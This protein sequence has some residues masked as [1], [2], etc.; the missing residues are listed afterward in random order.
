HGVTGSGKTEVYFEL[1]Q[2]TIERGKRGLFLVP[3]ISLTPQLIERFSRRF[4][5]EFAVIHSG[6]TDR[7]RT[8]FWWD[9]VEKRKKILIGVRSAL[10]CPIDDL[11][12]VIVDEEHEP[13]YKQD[14][15]FRYHARDAAVMLGKFFDCPVILGSATPSMESW[16]NIQQGKFHYHSIP[17]RV[18]IAKLPEVTMVDLREEKNKCEEGDP[19]WLSPTLKYK[20]A[21]QLEKKQQV[22]LF[23]NRRGEAHSVLC[24]D[25][26]K[27]YSCPNCD[28][29]LTLHSKNHLVCHYCDYHDTLAELCPDCG[30]DKVRDIG[31]GTE[32]VE[33]ELQRIF[34]NANVARADRDEIQRRNDYEN[35]I[36]NMMDRKIDILVGTQ[37]VAKGLDFP[38]VDL[39]GVVMADLTLNLPDFRSAER[40]FQLTVQVAGRAGRHSSNGEVVIQTYNPEHYSLSN[41]LSHNYIEF[42][43]QELSFR[44]ELAYPPAGQSAL[45]QIQG[46][47]AERTKKTGQNVRHF[48][49]RALEEW[50]S[51]GDL[52]GVQILGPAPAP[53]SKLRGRFRFQIFLKGPKG[54]AL[55]NLVSLVASH[56]DLVEP[57]TRLSFDIDPINIV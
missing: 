7:E 41:A 5:D 50:N 37:M 28:V 51:R 35:L 34:P 49:Q 25:C 10:F 55:S 56:L 46:P 43:Q 29:H 52:K 44:S 20:I 12:I 23:L 48:L 13:S 19:Y 21:D 47:T 2:S 16:Q 31:V 9:I 39:V 30:S 24:T 17:N 54:S 26:G 57:G 36:E 18:G 40:T 32:K 6:L 1:L 15:Q 22:L 33:K 27:N 4:G 53:L 42:A 45:I 11:G 8:N 14:S 3:E 38:G